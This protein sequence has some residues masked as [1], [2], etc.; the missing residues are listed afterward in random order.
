MELLVEF[1]IGTAGVIIV[2]FA[3]R[4]VFIKMR[5]KCTLI[6]HGAT[7]LPRSLPFVLNHAARFPHSVHF[8]LNDQKKKTLKT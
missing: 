8:Y 1:Y 3:N 4:F 5:C 2:Q 6:K 7:S